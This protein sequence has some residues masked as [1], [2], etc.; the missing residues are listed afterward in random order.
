MGLFLER[1]PARIGVSKGPAVLN[2][3][4]IEVEVE[5]RRAVSLE[6]VYR[7]DP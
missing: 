7:E 6:R 2:A 5:S 1:R 4:V 3:V